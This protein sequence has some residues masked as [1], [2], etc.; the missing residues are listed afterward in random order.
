MA[1]R[2]RPLDDGADASQKAARAAALDLC[3]RVV[4]GGGAPPSGAT[5]APSERAE[6]RLSAAS[7]ALRLATANK[8]CARELTADRWRALA[9]VVIDEDP[10]VRGEFARKLA[11]AVRVTRAAYR[12]TQ[13]P[14]VCA[15]AIVVGPVCATAS[16]RDGRRGPARAAAVAALYALRP[17]WLCMCYGHRGPV[18][19]TAPRDAFVAAI[20]R[21]RRDSSSDGSS[22][23]EYSRGTPPAF[24]RL[25]PA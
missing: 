23:S 6:L 25:L 10:V 21:R 24:P 5:A 15:T 1:A 19:P 2:A 8:A 14:C 16:M 12:E 7:A 13:W 3:F 4:D 9:E 18:C 20:P 17:S 11:D 22:P